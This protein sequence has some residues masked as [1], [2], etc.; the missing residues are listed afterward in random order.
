MKTIPCRDKSGNFKKNGEIREFYENGQIISL[1]TTICKVVE[2]FLFERLLVVSCCGTPLLII[3]HL[4]YIIYEN[5]LGLDFGLLDACNI[6][7]QALP[8]AHQSGKN[9]GILFQIPCGNSVLITFIKY[10]N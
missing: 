5:I 7:P 6:A 9:Q 4:K 8:A 3:Y 2:S 10:L 1:D